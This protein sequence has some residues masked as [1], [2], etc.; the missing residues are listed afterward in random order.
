MLRSPSLIDNLTKEMLGRRE[1]RECW[2]IAGPGRER[3]RL[4]SSGRRH[5]GAARRGRGSLDGM[6]FQLELSAQWMQFHIPY[7]QA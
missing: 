5:R 3:G 6:S 2:P 1:C 4:R 7:H